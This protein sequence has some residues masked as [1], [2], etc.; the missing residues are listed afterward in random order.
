MLYNMDHNPAF[1]VPG[2]HSLFIGVVTSGLSNSC[3]MA[4][5]F[6]RLLKPGSEPVKE[7][8]QIINFCSGL[9]FVSCALQ[10]QCGA[11]YDLT[12]GWH[13]H[14]LQEKNSIDCLPSAPLRSLLGRA[15]GRLNNSQPYWTRPGE[16]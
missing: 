4:L 9:Q 6:N 15:T 2:S 7:L 3:S 13:M 5:T 14:A 12:R 11:P 16:M 8:R 10:D 1:L